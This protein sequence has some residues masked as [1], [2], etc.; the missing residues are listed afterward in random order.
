MITRPTS[1]RSQSIPNSVSERCVRF[2]SGRVAIV[3]V[4]GMALFACQAQTDN[5]QDL[6]SQIIAHE[7]D[8]MAG[9]CDDSSGCVTVHISFDQLSDQHPS[10]ARDVINGRIRA[11]ALQFGA[12]S[13]SDTIAATAIVTRLASDYRSLQ[14]DF[15]EYVLPWEVERE[16]HIETDTCG[17][18]GVRSFRFEFTGGAHPNTTVKLITFA[19]ATG[20]SLLVDD[21][22]RVGARDGLTE[23]GERVFRRT[24]HIAADSSLQDAGFWFEPDGFRLTDNFLVSDSGLIFLYNAYDI[25]PY[26][27]GPTEL[28]LPYDSIAPYVVLDCF[29]NR[30]QESGKDRH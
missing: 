5:P 9:N 22:L 8:T 7:I 28:Y 23:F 27:M 1:R 11:M 30:D 18:I 24:W 15:P 3:A 26:S 21:V 4:L 17:L 19:A 2:A 10:L 6:G 13:V 12:D 20:D 25:A 16:V 14:K 29:V